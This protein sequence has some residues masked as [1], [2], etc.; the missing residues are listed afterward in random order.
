[1]LYL[2]L[3]LSIGL[4]GVLHSLL[5]A[6]W[7]K[8]LLK[9][10]FYRLVFNVISII[11]FGGVFLIYAKTNIDFIFQPPFNFIFSNFLIG[12]GFGFILAVLYQYNLMEFSGFDAFQTQKNET[13][14]QT[15]GY[16]QYV[17]HPLYSAII[18][19]M[20]FVFIAEPSIRNL[21]TG[22][23][24]TIY[25]LIGIHFE[26][27]KLIETFGKQYIDYQNKTPRLIPKFW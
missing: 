22:I 13:S 23:F 25:I 10:R 18:V 26:E 20:L 17:R 16:L 9:N 14:L 19:L 3:I 4:F 5:A 15:N 11:T 2:P 7:V 8:D 24:F 21:V 12:L 27:K 6:N 1:M